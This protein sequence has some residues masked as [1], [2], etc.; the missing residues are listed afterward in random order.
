M[1]DRGG[2]ILGLGAL[3]V[4]RWEALEA[5]FQAVYQIDLASAVYCEEAMTLRR[6]AVL[7][8]GLPAS[9]RVWAESNGGWSVTDHLLADVVEAVRDVRAAVIATVTTK[10]GQRLNL[11]PFRYPRPAP[12]QPKKKQGSWASSLARRVKR[13]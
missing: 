5:D 3:I 4:Q 7:V 9:A 2:G 13:R 12:K 10:P 8:R 6:F 11:E 1:E